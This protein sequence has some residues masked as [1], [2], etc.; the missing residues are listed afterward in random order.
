[1]LYS[2]LRL[3]FLWNKKSHVVWSITSCVNR[4][5]TFV[6]PRASL[7]TEMTIRKLNET[8]IRRLRAS[9]VI[10]SIAQCVLELI[11]NS[12]RSI[13]S[14][15]FFLSPS[16]SQYRLFYNPNFLQASMPLQLQLKYA[17]MSLHITYKSLTTVLAY[18]RKTW[19]KSDSAMP[20]QSVIR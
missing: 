19:I 17:W 6:V 20:R 9:L 3:I 11:Q 13:M 7:R 2:Q 8:V 10:T 1:M 5:Y 15:L 12:K 18:H 14:W 16:L 4:V